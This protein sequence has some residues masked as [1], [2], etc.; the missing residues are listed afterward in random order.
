MDIKGSERINRLVEALYRS[1]GDRFY[2]TRVT[3]T[4]G[5]AFCFTEKC[6]GGVWPDGKKFKSYPAISYKQ[7]DVLENTSPNDTILADR[8]R[9]FLIDGIDT[10][11]PPRQTPQVT[12]AD[13][14][15]IAKRRVE[16]ILARRLQDLIAKKATPEELEEQALAKATLEMLGERDDRIP[17]GLRRMGRPATR[18]QKNL[19]EVALWSVRAKELGITVQLRTNGAL[20]TVWKRNAE[21]KWAEH[22]KNQ[23]KASEQAAPAPTS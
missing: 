11:Q 16:E 9:K 4:P 20:N 1:L 17:K 12:M 19:E 14:E 23:V 5:I 15:D 2:M 22:V 8:L 10:A 3:H 21:L 13:I 6:R 7:L 18:R